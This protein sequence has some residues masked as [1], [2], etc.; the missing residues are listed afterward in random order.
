MC[1]MYMYVLSCELWT[2][3]SFRDQS[4]FCIGRGAGAMRGGGSFFSGKMK[5]GGGGHFSGEMDLGSL[6]PPPPRPSYKYG[7]VHYF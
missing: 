7:P 1:S 6:H 3:I 4:I 5:L 2:S